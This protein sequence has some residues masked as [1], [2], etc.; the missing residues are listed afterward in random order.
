MKFP[1]TIEEFIDDHKFVDTEEIYT[2]GSELITVFRLKQWLE[3]IEPCED[4]ISRKAVDKMLS[5]FKYS[6]PSETRDELLEDL[7]K[8][9]P[10]RPTVT[11]HI[12]KM[13][14]HQT[15]FSDIEMED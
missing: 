11:L 5:N 6:M 10:V 4:C 3:H 9:P 13:S 2:N 7:Q 1:A 14:K 15:D 12:D 8:L